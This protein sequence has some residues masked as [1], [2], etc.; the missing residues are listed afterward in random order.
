M[1]VRFIAYFTKLRNHFVVLRAKISNYY[2]ISAKIPLITDV[3]NNHNLSKYL[4]FGVNFTLSNWLNT[5][6][7]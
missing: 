1:R 6:V 2:K 3:R 5:S 4:F 7:L